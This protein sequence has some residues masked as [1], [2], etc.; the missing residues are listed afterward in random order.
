VAVETT[1]RVKRADVAEAERLSRPLKYLTSSRE[2][3]EELA[4]EILAQDPV[5]EGLICIF[6]A[7]EPCMTFEYQRSQD[8]S[9]R[10]LKLYPGKCLHL[11][12]YFIDPVF[13]F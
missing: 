7:L 4:R 3:K 8:R 1:E 11:Y 10:G 9:E 5:Q 2:S 6:T 13:G 12:Q